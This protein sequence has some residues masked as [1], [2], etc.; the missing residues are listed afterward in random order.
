MWSFCCG[1]W[2]EHSF[3]LGLVFHFSISQMSF[4]IFLSMDISSSPFR[5]WAIF[6]LGFFIS[7]KE[8]ITT[9][10]LS[11]NQV[12]FSKT[13]NPRKRFRSI[14]RYWRWFLVTNYFL[15]V[16][17]KAS[18]LWKGFP[19]SFWRKHL[20]GIKHSNLIRDVIFLSVSDYC[21]TGVMKLQ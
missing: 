15:F 18:L 3:L 13:S 21:K 2:G 16:S 7:P 8:T 17:F 20:G 4:P 10:S 12:W 19:I 5:N 6:L 14:S 11:L 1:D 9:Q